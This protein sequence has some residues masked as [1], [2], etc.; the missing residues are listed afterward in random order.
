MTV[1]HEP[2]GTRAAKRFA[3]FFLIPAVSLD[4]A[5]EL[6]AGACRS[7]P[8]RARE[9]RP[10][11]AARRNRNSDRYS[12]RRR[13]SGLGRGFDLKLLGE[14]NRLASDRRNPISRSCSISR[15]RPVSNARAGAQSRRCPAARSFRGRGARIPS[16]SARGIPGD[17]ARDPDASARRSARH[18]SGQRRDPRALDDLIKRSGRRGSLER[19]RWTSARP[20]RDPS[21]CRPNSRAPVAR[22]SVRRSAGNRQV[23]CC[24]GRWR[25]PFCANDP[26]ARILLP[27]DRCPIRA[28]AAAPRARPPAMRLLCGV[29]PGRIGVHPDFTA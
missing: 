3:R 8:A 15:W 7:R 29:R 14:L 5:A 23:D 28:P 13:L 18:S 12:D 19:C 27:I 10:A 1:T 24:R 17:R 11:L 25:T 9:A 6:L 26:R 20:S 16:P 21:A 4:V 22:I 2:G